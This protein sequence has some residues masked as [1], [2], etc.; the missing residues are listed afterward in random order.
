MNTYFGLLKKSQVLEQLLRLSGHA[1][2]RENELRRLESEKTRADCV[3][4]RVFAD[5][6][7][8]QTQ[9]IDAQKCAL[10][11]VEQITS[12]CLPSDSRAS[13]EER[14]LR[15]LQR[16]V[17]AASTLPKKSASTESAASVET[18]ALRAVGRDRVQQLSSQM[19]QYE[20]QLVGLEAELSRAI[21]SRLLQMTT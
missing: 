6:A 18:E 16:V 7:L 21:H 2:A 3:H 19:E 11:L 10:E 14:T 5:L 13:P 12:L 17:F 1:S 8:F 15:D 20:R 9:F 4:A